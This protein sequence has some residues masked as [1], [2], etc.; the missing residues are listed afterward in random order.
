M[1]AAQK[2]LVIETWNKVAPSAQA[3]ARLFYARL[4]EIDPTLRRLF[5]HANMAEQQ[6][7]LMLALT[8]VVQGL[9]RFETIAPALAELG[10]R[11]SKYRVVDRHYDSVGEA[12]LWTLGQ[13]LGSA[14]TPEVEAAWLAAYSAV[15]DAM[16]TGTLRTGALDAGEPM[17]DPDSWMPPEP[18]QR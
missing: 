13:G 3:T 18:G 11:H 8:T 12:L 16:R 15:S 9:D 17:L 7:K 10:R 5:D 1:L 14:W 2:T 6:R 4:F